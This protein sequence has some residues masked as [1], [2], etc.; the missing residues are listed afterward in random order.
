M[1]PIELKLQK[2][3]AQKDQA[4]AERNKIL[5][6]FAWFLYRKNLSIIQVGLT[7]HPAEDKTW[8]LAWSNILVI[9][10]AGTSM[11]WHFHESEMWMFKG[12]PRMGGWKWDG[13]TTDEKYERLLEFFL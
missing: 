2:V 12:L 7:K 8:D 11:S 6:A 5:A 1:N 9:I 3:I 4:Y 13:H 10:Y